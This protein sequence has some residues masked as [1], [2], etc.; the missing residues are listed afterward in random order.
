MSI[1]TASF[2]KRN[3][4]GFRWCP[5][6]LRELIFREFRPRNH[7]LTSSCNFKRSGNEMYMYYSKC[8]KELYSHW[9]LL[10]ITNRI[11]RERSS[12]GKNLRR[13]HTLILFVRNMPALVFI[14]SVCWSP[15]FFLMPEFKLLLPGSSR[16]TIKF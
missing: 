1:S 2:K 8:R 15:G 10:H 3:Y 12:L 14:Y 7:P 9:A 5:T 13:E 11:Y 4:L 16:F 6:K